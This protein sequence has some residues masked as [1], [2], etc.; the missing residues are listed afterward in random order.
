MT[1]RRIAALVAAA[2]LGLTACGAGGTN[3]G[4]PATETTDVVVENTTPT[5]VVNLITHDSWA[6]SPQVQQQFEA[7]T[8][9]RLQVLPVGDAGTLANQIVL[10]KDNPLG[11]VVFGIDNTFSSRVEE[12]DAIDG[13]LHPVTQG[14]VCLNVDSAWFAEHDI[15]EPNTLD[16]IVR[17]EYAGLTVVLN[18]ASSSPGLAFL[19]ATIGA[20]GES[21]HFDPTDPVDPRADYGAG[22]QEYW[23]A[24]RANDVAVADS[25]SDGYYAQFSGAGEGGTRPIVVSY[26]TSPAFTVDGDHST[27]RALLNTCFRQTEYAGVLAGATN[28][29]AGQKLLDFLTGATFQADVPEQM[30][31]YPVDPAVELPA[32][33]VRFA[34]Q[35]EHPYEVAA[36][37]IAANRDAWIDE[38]NRVV[39]E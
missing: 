14:D 30:F 5:G 20:F 25:W 36:S 24:L 8:G 35:A 22:W 2:L 4:E 19:L 33:W 3:Q 10:T 12:A 13:G 26:S 27:T 6:I 11:D 16:D 15:P 38:W 9:L 39:V 7:E 32:D 21:G 18:P 17:P 29:V 23:R 37:E 1:N 31:M 28:P 34:P